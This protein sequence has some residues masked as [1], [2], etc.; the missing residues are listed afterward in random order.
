VEWSRQLPETTSVGATGQLVSLAEFTVLTIPGQLVSARTPAFSPEIPLI[1]P[2]AT[3]A[4]KAAT[5]TERS[6][7]LPIVGFVLT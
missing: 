6:N 4:E 1:A 2:K 7:L 3:A 5:S